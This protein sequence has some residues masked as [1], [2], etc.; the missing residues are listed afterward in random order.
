MGVCAD[1]KST[2]M[3]LDKIKQKVLKKVTRRD[4]MRLCGWIGSA[5]EAQ[6]VLGALEDYGYIRLSSV[7]LSDKLRAGRPKNAV[8]TV[9]PRVYS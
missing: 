8:Y 4:I 1:F 5:E 3:A 6:T 9:N 2:L 7:D